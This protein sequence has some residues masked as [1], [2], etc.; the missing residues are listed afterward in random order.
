MAVETFLRVKME[1][2]NPST[3][4]PFDGMLLRP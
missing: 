1:L 2:G 3:H 4:L